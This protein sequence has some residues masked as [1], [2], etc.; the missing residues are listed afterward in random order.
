MRQRTPRTRRP[1]LRAV[2]R[3]LG[4]FLAVAASAALLG[5]TAAAPADAR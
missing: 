4:V 5:L 2:G 3:R 1:G